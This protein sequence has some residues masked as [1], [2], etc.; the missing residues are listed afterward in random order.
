MLNV[1]KFDYEIIGDVDTGNP[2]VI[3]QYWGVCDYHVSSAELVKKKILEKYPKAAIFLK[4]DGEA[5]N[6]LII[7]S[8]G[9]KIYDK[10]AVQKVVVNDFYVIELLEKMKRT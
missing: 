4:M 9:Q 5:T 7:T 3:I 2:R 1:R 6:N 8:N 10:P